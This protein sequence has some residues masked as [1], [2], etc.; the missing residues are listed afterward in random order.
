M[1]NLK[2]LLNLKI[3]CDVFEDTNLIV[4]GQS[5]ADNDLS[6]KL[7]NVFVIS[8][9]IL[10]SADLISEK[11]SKYYDL[12][13]L[14]PDKNVPKTIGMW[15]RD[16]YNTIYICFENGEIYSL[17]IDN[18]GVQHCSISHDLEC[19]VVD[20]Q[21]SPDEELA[22]VVCDS[23]SLILLNSEFFSLAEIDL[24]D[25]CRGEN[26]LIS[27]GWGKK[28][29]Q[30]HGSEGK[31]AAKS[32]PTSVDPSFIEDNHSVNLTWRGDSN[33]F[34]ASYWC[35]EKNMRKVK[36]FN[37]DG[38]LLSTSEDISGLNEP[39]CWRPSGNL[40]ALPQ[41]LPNKKVVSFLEKNGLK[42]GD[43]TLP[44]DTKVKHISWNEGSNI[45]CTICENQQNHAEE[46]MLW[47]TGNYHWY[48]KQKFKFVSLTRNVWW[49][50]E[51]PNRIYALCEGGILQILEWTSLVSTSYH[52]QSEDKSY[53]SVIDNN[54]ILLTSFKEAVIP[55]P[56][57][58]YKLN[59]SDAVNHVMFA[60]LDGDQPHMLCAILFNGDVAF[61]KDPLSSPTILSD[62]V[63]KHNI[64]EE[65]ISLSHWEWV[66]PDILVF[67]SSVKRETHIHQLSISQD[68]LE[69]RNVTKFQG[70]II[71]CNRR[72][73]KLVIQTT[74]G[75]LF[76]YNTKS[77]VVTETLSLIEP[78]YD[79]KV[80]SSGLFCLSELSR[81]Y[82]N[83][84]PINFPSIT[85][86]VTSFIL[87]DPYLLV[88][89]SSHKLVILQ[90]SDS[91]NVEIS[92]RKLER[93]SRLVTTFDNSVV[94]QAPRG[95]LETIQPR[96]LTILT[97]GTLIDSKQFKTALSLM[98]KQRLDLN[99]IIDHNQKLFLDE[100]NNFVNQIDPQWIT[101][102]VTELS[103]EDVTANLYKQYY[104]KK[105]TSFLNGSK[106]KSVCEALLSV[107]ST[108][109]LRKKYIFPILSALVKIGEMSKAIQLASNEVAMQHLMFIV[110]SN[111]LYMEAL[112][113][114]DLNAALK[115]AGKSQ[116]DPKEYIP[117][118][119]SLKSME[120]NYMR[121]VIDKKLKRYESALMHISKCCDECEEECLKFIEDNSLY[122]SALKI[123]KNDLKRSS[124]IA[125][126]YAAY[127]FKERHYEESGIM[128]LRSDDKEKAL[129]SFTRAGNW[130]Q[131][132]II[133]MDS[134]FSNEEQQKHA[135]NVCNM[136]ISAH[137]YSE[138][139]ILSSEWLLDHDKAVEMYTQAR[140]WKEAIYTAKKFGKSS[141]IDTIIKDALIETANILSEDINTQSDKTK[142]YVERLKTVRI[143][144]ENRTAYI[145]DDMS[146]TASETSSTSSVRTK[147]FQSRSSKN[148]K[149]M[150]RK[151]WS[152]KE[153]NP[154]EEEALVATLSSI[155]SST[156]KYVGE[157]HSACSSLLVFQEDELAGKLQSALDEWLS[158]IDK[159]KNIIWP[160]EAGTNEASVLDEKFKYPPEVSIK[161]EWKFNLLKS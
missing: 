44:A 58:S 46:V 116:K 99:L 59:C 6:S 98:R 145:F 147:S 1:K 75:K 22:A 139:A 68:G 39:I 57:S 103:G 12:E 112:G 106:V 21:W 86:K 65:M 27:V 108:E 36:I 152:L 121:F 10:Y 37:M 7:G 83:N 90:C 40:I 33:M 61:F 124:V 60:P 56:M 94:L 110:D 144:K 76:S 113:V 137:K 105:D 153:G 156:E 52:S 79:I 84:V 89:T 62:L 25:S 15:Y 111:K 17:I 49:D 19:K 141:L 31:N 96:A 123:F 50:K 16:L 109:D 80:H 154:R 129:Q 149:K 26:E 158:I 54:S 102:L 128:Y 130:R 134:N 3:H 146:D 122:P 118:L 32:K 53:V 45:L 74:D 159:S 126:K 104:K 132:M 97:L 24:N 77:L 150:S 87:K 81:L 66:S 151:M 2:L 4:S 63:Q 148:T 13:S 34:A 160:K 100:V 85:C 8:K 30:F 138:A 115:I 135:E 127:L 43:F 120:P 117:Y 131:C 67:C 140:C 133:V 136:L 73:E 55:P 78:C 107:M 70:N 119:N 29:T 48:I 101:L 42:H 18:N 20:I 143:E 91:E 64:S 161:Q 142:K 28:E 93:G 72:A 41:Q 92:E 82:L 69:L 114:Y 23:D 95:N 125:S 14:F 47:V 5:S 157:V 71:T 38:V 51:R 35:S 11:A 9:N 155:I 88:T